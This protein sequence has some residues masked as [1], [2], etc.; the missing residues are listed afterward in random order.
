MNEEEFKELVTQSWD[1]YQDTVNTSIFVMGQYGSGKTTL[2]TTAPKPILLN[3][4]DPNGTLVIE[5]L[6]A[7]GKLKKSDI[8]I[9]KYWS[10]TAQNPVEYPRWEKQLREDIGKGFLNHFA[11]YAIDTATFWTEAISNYAASVDP[12]TTSA[13]MR[14]ARDTLP[15][16][17][18]QEINTLVL[19]LVNTISSMDLVF[20]LTC[21]LELNES[22]TGDTEYVPS[23]TKK[24]RTQ[25]PARF[26]EKW[27][28]RAKNKG[29]KV[30]HEIVT[31]PV[32]NIRG[33][34][35]LGLPLTFEPDITKALKA[36]GIQTTNK[37]ALPI[38]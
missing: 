3:S 11:T 16:R 31:G 8:L 30:T 33:S 38:N 5:R 12:K 27:V 6:I 13:H 32:G 2:I 23:L 10:D 18:Y 15:I 26:S 37:P 4:F 1:E 29:G 35:Q 14:G 19:S 28:I 34:S 21:H 36:A 17:A 24:L 25:L 9:R 7:E 20:V 22:E